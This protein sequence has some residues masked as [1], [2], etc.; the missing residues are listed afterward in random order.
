MEIRGKTISYSSFLKKKQ[1]NKDEEKLLNDLKQLMSEP[2]LNHALITAKNLSLEDLRN[3]QM[4]G[5]KLRRRQNGLTK[6][7]M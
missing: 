6:G 7:R 1:E 3:K 4:E 5:V 2:I